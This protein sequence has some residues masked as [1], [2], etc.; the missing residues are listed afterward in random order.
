MKA[1][2]LRSLAL[3]LLAAPWY[4]A[5]AQFRD[6]PDPTET[7]VSGKTPETIILSWP[8]YSYRL[9][10][11]MIAQYGQPTEA[12][13]EA[14]VW[15]DNGP[16]KRTVVHREAPGGRAFKR[17]K[18]RLEQSAAYRADPAKLDLLARYDREIEAD[19]SEGRLTSRADTEAENFLA[20]NLAD[21]VL[22]GRREPREAAQL[23]QKLLHEGPA[24]KSSSYRD[25]LMFGRD[26]QFANPESP[27]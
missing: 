23:R 7:N 25:G 12:R 6:E 20:L 4:P 17:N 3:A 24:G 1:A 21:E 16:W 27:D 22:T 8:T 2:L 11:A 19:L 5:S 10:R 13:D 26:D 18:G 14:L 9:A 15:H